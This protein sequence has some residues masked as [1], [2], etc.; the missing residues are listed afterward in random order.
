MPVSKAEK[1]AYNDEIKDIKK[2]VDNLNSQIRDILIRKKKMPRISSYYNVE[3]SFKQMDVIDSYLKMNDL[4][5]EMLGLKNESVLNNARKE[6]YKILQE[7]EEI[8]GNQIDRSLRENDDYLINIQKLNPKQILNFVQRL[9]RVFY[10]LRTS[11]G[12]GSKWKWSFVELQSRVAVI[13]KNITSFSDLARLRDPRKE[14]YYDRRDLMELCKESL[15]EAAKQYRTKYE[16]SGKAREDLK[17]SIDL[18]AALRK[19][20]V[21]FGED[22]EA[23]K[24]KNTIDAARLTLEAEDKSSD[25][26]KKAKTS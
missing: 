18:L 13:T 9:H 19:I 16:L 6:F 1:A 15:T 22:E 7:V 11:V 2:T 4:S 12:E 21:I 20:H 23:T 8:V 10:N 26:E 25:K 24:L 14:F 5:V 3:I 17:K